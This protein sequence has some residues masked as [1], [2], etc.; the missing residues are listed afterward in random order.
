VGLE[1]TVDPGI[2]FVPLSGFGVR[3]VGVL[4]KKRRGV[5]EGVILA[6]TVGE[7]V[8]VRVLVMVGVGP[9]TVGKGP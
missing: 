2:K 7:G 1:T 8:T 4:M 6:V 5:G 9:V 3:G